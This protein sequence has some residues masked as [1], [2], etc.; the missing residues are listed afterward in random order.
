MFDIEYYLTHEEVNLMNNNISNIGTFVS[1]H[2][3]RKVQNLARYLS[4]NNLKR[5]FF[6]LNKR[7]AVGIDGV[8]D[9]NY[10]HDLDTN[11]HNL[12]ERLVHM[13]YKPLPSRRVYIPKP[14]SNKKRPLGIPCLED[15]IV[16]YV[17]AEILNEIYER[18]FINESYGFRPNRN[19]HQAVTYL[20]NMIVTRKVNYIVDADI[21]GFFDNIDHEWMIKFLEY[22]IDDRRFIELIS[23][24]LKSGII[25]NEMYYETDKGTPQG[26]IISPIL[27]NI[28]LHFVQDLWVEKIVKPKSRGEVYYVRY[29]DDSQICFQYKDDAERYYYSLITRLDKFGLEVAENKTRIIAFGRFTKSDMEKK[30][31][32][33]KP[34]TFSF[35]GFTFY[36]SQTKFTHKFTVKLKTDGKKLSAKMRKA[37]MWLKHIRHHKVKE[38]ICTINRSLRGHY[39]Y[40][41]VSDNYKCLCRI[42]WH[43]RWHIIRMLF[44]VLRSRGN[45]RRLTWD[46]YFNK[47]LKENP[48]VNPKIYI[49]LYSDTAY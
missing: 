32:K 17:M 46:T 31:I 21:K 45:R 33:G 6:K 8:T 16:Q 15:K 24:F 26:G 20:R 34:N 30:G 47:L 42:R 2:P 49:K 18:M 35:L 28:Y 14:G 37:S 22:R 19:C 1:E 29:A 9:D 39:Q 38:I 25:E 41:G 27:A 43:I 23:R 4:E 36:L 11:I 40:Y 44:K 5:A 12:Y 10:M 3:E 13:T 48:I 7:K